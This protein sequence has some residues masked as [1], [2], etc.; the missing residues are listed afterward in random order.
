[1]EA[2]TFMQ[3]LVAT[4]MSLGGVCLFV[5]AVLSGQFN[6]AEAPKFKAYRMEVAEDE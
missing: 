3:F 2:Q 6:N 5:W 1:M 4:F